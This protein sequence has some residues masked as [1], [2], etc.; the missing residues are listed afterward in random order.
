MAT[1]P[2][3]AGTLEFCRRCGHEVR[4]AEGRICPKCDRQ[5][6][7]EAFP[8]SAVVRHMAEAEHRR[9]RH[10]VRVYGKGA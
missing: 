4:R 2:R 10:N 7:A 6:F 1:D 3:I 5:R 8:R 9:G